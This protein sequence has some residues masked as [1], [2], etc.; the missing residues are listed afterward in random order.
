[1]GGAV[2]VEG[3]QKVAAET[4]VIRDSVF[5]ENK[6]DSG[7]AL[8]LKSKSIQYN[9]TG[10]TFK[11]NEAAKYGG[12][13]YLGNFSNIYMTN[14]QIDHNSAT[15][16]G[17]ALYVET[18]A[19]ATIDSSVLDSNS[20]ATN[21]T[22]GYG[23]HIYVSISCG[24]K[25][26]N[27]SLSWGVATMGGGAVVVNQASFFASQTS[28]TFNK[29][30]GSPGD[31]GAL[32]FVEME[33]TAV[34]E[35]CI[36]DNNIAK[37]DGGAIFSFHST[38]ILTSCDLTSNQAGS[39]GGAVEAADNDISGSSITFA[40]CYVANNHAT[41]AGALAVSTI[42]VSIY[43]NRLWENN[44]GKY[45]GAI[46]FVACSAQ[47]TGITFYNNTAEITG[48]AIYSSTM[49][50]LN[51]EQ[52]RFIG[53]ILT[54]QIE[55]STLNTFSNCIF[56]SNTGDGAAIGLA[57][58]TVNVTGSTFK[59]QNVAT[60]KGA[61]I[62]CSRASLFIA[63][64]TFSENIG[65]NGLISFI[66]GSTVHVTLVQFLENT[67]GYGTIN[68]ANGTLVVDSC[69]FHQNVA[70]YGSAVYL[71][72]TVT[73]FSNSICTQNSAS[74]GS[75]LYLS[76]ATTLTYIVENCTF[77]GNSNA[78]A[79]GGVIAAYG[80]TLSVSDS[81]FGNNSA[82]SGASIYI[83]KSTLSATGVTFSQNSGTYGAA[84]YMVSSQSTI[85]HSNISENSGLQFGSLVIDANS[86]TTIVGSIFSRNKAEISGGAIYASGNY[87]LQA[88][89]QFVNNNA[90]RGGAIYST[91]GKG[92]IYD[93]LFYSNGATGDGGAIYAFQASLQIFRST[94]T[95]NSAQNYG[96]A[97]FTNNVNGS[98]QNSTLSSNSAIYGGAIS[99]NSAQWSVLNTLLYK[100]NATQGGAVFVDQ[101]NA[102]FAGTE[103]F[104]NSAKD[105]GGALYLTRAA[106][107]SISEC[108]IFNN[109][110][111]N[112]GGG[113]AVFDAASG[114]ISHSD[115]TQNSAQQGGTVFLDSPITIS[116]SSIIQGISPEG[117]GSGIY[118][119][120]SPVEK[121]LRVTNTTLTNS[122]PYPFCCGSESLSE[123]TERICNYPSCSKDCGG[124]E[125]TC[126]CPELPPD[127]TCTCTDPHYYG[128]FCNI[129]DTCMELGYC[130]NGSCAFN[131]TSY[132]A[133]C[134]DV[135]N[136]INVTCPAG[137]FCVDML[138]HYICSPC[139]TGQTFL[140]GV[141]VDSCLIHNGYCDYHVECTTGPT[142]GPCPTGFVGNGATQCIAQCGNG[143]CDAGIGENC[144]TCPLDCYNNTA[145]GVCGDHFCQAQQNET[146]SSC[147]E[148]CGLCAATPCIPAD[149]SRHGTC[150]AGICVCNSPW[151]GPACDKDNKP[152][153][154]DFP[155]GGGVQVS[156]G[157]LGVSFL[158]TIA[159]IVEQ[160]TQGRAV[161]FLNITNQNY[162]FS[163]YNTTNTR[164]HNQSTTISDF[165]ACFDCDLPFYVQMVSSSGN[166]NQ[167]FR[168]NVT[169]ENGAYLEFMV[170]FQKK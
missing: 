18:Y 97:I 170:S 131:S 95:G 25:L 111:N 1:M 136:C 134:S 110:A 137:Q 40:D 122:S 38:I 41:N 142:C 148:D 58:A 123:M 121:G 129:L 93:T 4:V 48:G 11:L 43:G 75:V 147:P 133:K 77:I 145:C 44:L 141:C 107:L 32:H 156:P 153:T 47:I 89:C 82:P 12:A 57:L 164:Q 33:S 98:V 83:E 116:H 60:N 120:S 66:G 126:M 30:P 81:L 117:M 67:L 90:S 86:T 9:I 165:G 102:S 138:F 160:D 152:I 108:R 132:M 22:A 127:F 157:N 154:I 3:E 8:T 51:I 37:S 140:S 130:A 85:T 65:D 36:F 166:K 115:F 128:A 125:G 105:G 91:V 5:A 104:Q 34:L 13:I 10:C 143:S 163:L 155:T 92:I 20:A 56:E 99:G 76:G 101:G 72:S 68:G 159:S 161:D 39:Q 139:P 49:T 31:G 80:L 27:S 94:I 169:L 23:G 162:T 112:R 71:D 74:G 73:K 96:G 19:T 14:N 114:Q 119:N 62:K 54:V 124:S 16:A 17:G 24:L 42:K 50:E 167:L 151:G 26:T 29:A 53:N 100:N 6:A 35:S 52:V 149:C 150:N 146:C 63:N 135:N 15:L 84:I 61:T 158:L 2:V 69:M 46:Y 106:V 88:N 79:V 113:I 78:L 59:G 7:G 118:I 144:V 168:Y 64:S 28:F 103:L 21:N 45:G 87:N 109:T 55:N 70:F